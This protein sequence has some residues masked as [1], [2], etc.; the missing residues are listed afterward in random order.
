[1]ESSTALTTTQ[2]PQ[3]LVLPTDLDPQA[4]IKTVGMG[5][6]S[7]LTPEQQLK[8]VGAICQSVG[9]N[10]L[11]MPIRIIEM[12]GRK[13]LYATAECGAQLRSLH[14]VNIEVT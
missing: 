9:L 7:S 4:L 2:H 5:D 3:A 10:A 13:V 14:R 6:V 8:Y 12:D 1:M 11:T